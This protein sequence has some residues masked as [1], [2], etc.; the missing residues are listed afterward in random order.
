MYNTL[1]C[2]YTEDG[3]FDEAER[4][5]KNAADYA[6]RAHSA[7]YIKVASALFDLASLYTKRGMLEK[8]EPLFRRSLVLFEISLGPQDPRLSQN[9]H[10]LADLYS[11]QQNYDQAEKLICK[12]LTSLQKTRDTWTELRD[13]N[14]VRKM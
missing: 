2:L 3:K 4:Q 12:S 1:T 11:K 14:K 8:S 5:L 13:K 7:Q 10:K 9:I 6:E